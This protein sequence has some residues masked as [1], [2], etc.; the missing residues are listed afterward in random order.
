MEGQEVERTSEP[1]VN[2]YVRCGKSC[3]ES[4]YY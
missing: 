3:E 2:V 4:G 1:M